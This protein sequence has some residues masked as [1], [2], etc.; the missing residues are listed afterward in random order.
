MKGMKKAILLRGQSKRSMRHIS[1]R[2]SGR[3]FCRV[4]VLD[5]L[6][7]G[8]SKTIVVILLRLSMAF[9]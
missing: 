7:L 5:L 8:Q 4:H 1:E 9:D 3:E 2:S 6:P